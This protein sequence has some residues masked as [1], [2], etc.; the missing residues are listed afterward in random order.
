MTWRF[1]KRSEKYEEAQEMY[2][3]AM[4]GREKLLEPRHRETLIS[5]SRLAYTLQYDGKKA[6]AAKEQPRVLGVR[7]NILMKDHPDALAT[8]D[9]LAA[10]LI[11]QGKFEAAEEMQRRALN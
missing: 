5:V 9:N 10:V 3:R 2:R 8:M 11:D 6:A 4:N 1:F 7:E